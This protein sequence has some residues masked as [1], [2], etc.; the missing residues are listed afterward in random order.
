MLR[1]PIPYN[2]VQFDEKLLT[3]AISYEDE[4]KKP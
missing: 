2:C 1:A 4:F 3:F